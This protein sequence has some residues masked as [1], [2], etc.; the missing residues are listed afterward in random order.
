LAFP[1]LTIR[2]RNDEDEQKKR[3]VACATA[4]FREETSK[5]QTTR[6]CRV[7]AMHNLG[8]AAL[9][10]KRFFA[11]QQCNETLCYFQQQWL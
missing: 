1:A 4:E 10:C 6:Q 8:P 3:A 9:A 7:A 5:K 2:F 11:V